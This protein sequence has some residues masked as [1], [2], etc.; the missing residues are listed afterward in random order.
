MT[1]PAA[2]RSWLWAAWDHGNGAGTPE[3]AAAVTAIVTHLRGD[4]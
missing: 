2:L 3:H 1:V 4:P